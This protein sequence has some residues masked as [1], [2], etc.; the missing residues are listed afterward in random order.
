MT[1]LTTKYLIRDESSEL[2]DIE[3]TLEKLKRYTQFIE[4]NSLS[5]AQFVD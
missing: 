4:T 1:I 3:S 5:P 2:I